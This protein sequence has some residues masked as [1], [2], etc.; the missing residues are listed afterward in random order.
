[1]PPKIFLCVLV[2]KKIYSS[3][4]QQLESGLEEAKTVREGKSSSVGCSCNSKRAGGPCCP[5]FSFLSLFS[6]HLAL[7]TDVVVEGP[8]RA[9]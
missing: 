6:H 4:G 3:D 5:C 9:G 2:P 1:M 7:D 8:R